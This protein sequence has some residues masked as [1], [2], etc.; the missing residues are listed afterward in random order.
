MRYF[1]PE[2][3]HGWRRI[4]KIAYE[5]DRLKFF[6]Y[7]NVD[8]KCEVPTYYFGVEALGTTLSVM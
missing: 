8:C 1:V 6:T 2:R 3:W 4:G 5:A 7:L